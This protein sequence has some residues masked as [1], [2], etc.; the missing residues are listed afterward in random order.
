MV[1]HA[2][3]A[4]P[5]L[6][7][8]LRTIERCRA[9]DPEFTAS[10]EALFGHPHRNAS[11]SGRVRALV[12]L[13]AEAVIPQADED[14]MTAAIGWAA[15]EGAT[16]DEVMC[17]LEIAC[18][19]GL[20]TVSVGLPILLEE[21]AK[22][23]ID[24][25]AETP[26]HAELKERIETTGPRP[27]PLNSIYAAIL[28]MDPDYFAHR[29]RFIDLPWERL[30]VLDPAVKHLVSIAIDAVSP[31]H[32]VDGLRKH[33]HEALQIGVAP[34]AILE[35]LQLA[36]VTGLRTLDVGLPLVDRAFPPAARAPGRRNPE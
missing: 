32:Y 25:P 15:A 5:R 17:V 16:V 11:L 19:I 28:R 14:R 20:H 22:Q 29:I 6:G 13:A 2:G 9:L 36:S 3:S 21:M 8:H 30:E 26:R 24:L 12:V 23:G 4:E 33:I 35:V 1:V 31:Q 27:R 18:S 10:A 7:W 34:R